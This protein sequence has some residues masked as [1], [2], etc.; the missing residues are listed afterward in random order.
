MFLIPTSN[1]ILS[2]SQ[3]LNHFHPQ[4]LLVNEWNACDQTTLKIY[5]HD[6]WCSHV[7]AHI[8]IGHTFYNIRGN[9]VCHISK[10]LMSFGHED[11]IHSFFFKFDDQITSKFVKEM[12]SN[13]E[14]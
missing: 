8:L 7:N 1:Y 6:K 12:K 9:T 11:H 13:F 10:S 4:T 14:S 5:W 3:T 2:Q